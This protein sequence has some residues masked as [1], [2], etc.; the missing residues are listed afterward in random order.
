VHKTSSTEYVQRAETKSHEYI[1]GGDLKAEF[2]ALHAEGEHRRRMMSVSAHDRIAGRPLR[3]KTNEEFMTY[4]QSHPGVVFMREDEIA[5]FAL[6]S[7]QAI[8]E[9]I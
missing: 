2:D 4:I 6:S 9:A 3:T 1:Y 8:R 5:H 7:R